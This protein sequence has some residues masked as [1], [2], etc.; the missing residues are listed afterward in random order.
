MRHALV[1]PRPP[2]RGAGRVRPGRDPEIGVPRAQFAPHFAAARAAGLHSV[3]HSGE[4]TGP[5]SVWEA[6]TLLGAERIG[7]GTSSVRDPAL[8]AHLAERGIP[9]EVCPTS[10]IATRVVERLE[11][12]PIRGPC[13]TPVSSSR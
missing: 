11:E 9:L 1:R 12:H 13:A 7:H 8:L 4:S 6:V 5:E 2:P 3:P 10:N